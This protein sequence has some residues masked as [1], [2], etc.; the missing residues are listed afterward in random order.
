MLFD[1]ER[2]LRAGQRLPLTLTVEFSGQR[3]REITT[4]VFVKNS[5][6]TGGHE[7]R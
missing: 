4:Q 2:P 5:D 1:L 3:K 6:E 7:H